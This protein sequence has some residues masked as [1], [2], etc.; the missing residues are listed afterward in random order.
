MPWSDLV[1]DPA[2]RIYTQY[3]DIATTSPQDP[4]RHWRYSGRGLDSHSQ[5]H[6]NPYTIEYEPDRFDTPVWPGSDTPTHTF[7]VVQEGWKSHPPVMKGGGSNNTDISGYPS[8]R[9]EG[10]M[11]GYE[12]HF[13]H[14][15]NVFGDG[16]RTFRYYSKKCATILIYEYSPAG[17][18]GDTNRGKVMG[19]YPDGAFDDLD[20]GVDVDYNQYYE[21]DLI[22]ED[23]TTIDDFVP[24]ELVSPLT[25]FYYRHEQNHFNNWNSPGKT[26]SNDESGVTSS[27]YAGVYVFPVSLHINYLNLASGSGLDIVAA[28]EDEFGNDL[29]PLSGHVP[30]TT[31]DSVIGPSLAVI[32]SPAGAKTMAQN[33]EVIIQS[34]FQPII[35][36]PSKSSYIRKVGLSSYLG[37]IWRDD[38]VIQGMSTYGY[39]R[40]P[41]SWPFWLS[42]NST[43]HIPWYP[44]TRAPAGADQFDTGYYKVRWL[45]PPYRYWIPEDSGAIPPAD[46]GIGG[47]S[48]PLRMRQRRSQQAQRTWV[49]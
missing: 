33:S 32:D 46:G 10:H 8:N 31:G 41:S 22:Y 36:L 16:S 7:P 45:V 38:F 9:Y 21:A 39:P 37:F 29:D 17:W 1:T 20:Y 42:W 5:P 40:D 44:V 2:K 18:W 25:E 35:D 28:Y 27:T 49:T 48:P 4:A 15:S 26:W 24:Y 34:D 13:V 47:A 14:K 30:N 23:G 12:S 6:Q 11:T 3:Y 43:A 19:P